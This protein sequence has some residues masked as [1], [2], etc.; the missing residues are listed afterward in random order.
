MKLVKPTIF[1]AN[2]G[3]PNLHI[4][5]KGNTLKH[6]GLD[7]ILVRLG[8]CSIII[9]NADFHCKVPW[10]KL[11]HCCKVENVDVAVAQ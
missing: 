6:R 5:R 7:I 3:D 10:M 1:Y 8:L 2:V 9:F 4:W 11:S